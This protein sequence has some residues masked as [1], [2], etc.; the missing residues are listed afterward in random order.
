MQRLKSRPRDSDAH[1]QSRIRDFSLTRAMHLPTFETSGM[2]LLKRFTLANDNG[3]VTH[4]FYP[5]FPPN[6]SASDVVRWLSDRP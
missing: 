1:A 4:V 3:T 5:V 6:R 2:V